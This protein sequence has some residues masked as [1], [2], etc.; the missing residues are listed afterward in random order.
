MVQT[1]KPDCSI[2]EPQISKF[3]D[4]LSADRGL[5]WP[6]HVGKFLFV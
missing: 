6:S 4:P 3:Q 1:D 2:I 5:A